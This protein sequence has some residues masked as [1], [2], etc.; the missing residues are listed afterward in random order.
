LNLL[1][2]ATLVKVIQNL[3]KELSFSQ[4]QIQQ[5]RLSL[6]EKTSILDD[7]DN[8]SLMILL[9]KTIEEN[10]LPKDSFTRMLFSSVLTALISEVSF[11]LTSHKAKMLIT[12]F[13]EK[14]NCFLES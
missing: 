5:L 13:I 8:D 2:K 3:Q 14:T 4:A 1:D 6:E 11:L 9:R 12:H 10:K 7:E